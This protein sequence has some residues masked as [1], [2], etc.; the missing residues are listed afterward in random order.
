M[1]KV[2][3][4]SDVHNEHWKCNKLLAVT[5]DKEAILVVAGDINWKGRSVKDLDEVADNFL[6]VVAVL[7]NHDWWKL[8]LQDTSKHISCKP[9][10][11]ILED[12]SIVI[13]NILFVGSTLWTDMSSPAAIRMWPGVMNDARYIRGTKYSKLRDWNLHLIHTNSV[14]YIGSHENSVV[15]YKAK[16]LVTHHAMSHLSIA[17]QYMGSEY[18]V[19]Y[20]TPLEYLL[21]G[22]DYH[23]HGHVHKEVRQEV[24]GCKILSNPLGYPGENPD[25]VYGTSILI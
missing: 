6:A 8:A 20:Y 23:L 22:F 17:P 18:N 21:E 9:N 7:G 25:Y 12:S 4:I 1:T 10:V 2:I 16:V 24:Y 3:Y 15:E 13:E 14:D 19:F 5:P 11:H